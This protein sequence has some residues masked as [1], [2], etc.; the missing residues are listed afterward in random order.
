MLLGGFEP[1]SG[2]WEPPML[3]QLNQF[4]PGYTTEADLIYFIM[5]SFFKILKY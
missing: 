1:P 2:G 3:S 4:W 5:Q